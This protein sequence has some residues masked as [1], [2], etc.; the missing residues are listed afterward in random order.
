[1]DAPG[2]EWCVQCSTRLPED[3]QAQH[4][5]RLFSYL[6]QWDRSLCAS[7]EADAAVDALVQQW[8][9]HLRDDPAFLLRAARLG[10][11][12]ALVGL[13]GS[14]R[15]LVASRAIGLLTAVL[16]ADGPLTP[17][18][19]QVEALLKGPPEGAGLWSSLLNTVS[20]GRLCVRRCALLA[21][22]AVAS[23]HAAALRASVSASSVATMLR[24]VA[25]TRGCFT[26][27][28]VQAEGKIEEWVWYDE[29]TSKDKLHSLSAKDL[30]AMFADRASESS[31]TCA[32]SLL[33][34]VC[35]K[36]L[37][38]AVSAIKAAK[39]ALQ[40]FV[41][42][43]GSEHFSADD[44]YL[45][46]LGLAAVLS[47][48]GPDTAPFVDANHPCAA[49]MKE[50]VDLFPNIVSVLVAAI[51]KLTAP[52]MAD[53]AKQTGGKKHR[54]ASRKEDEQ[55]VHKTY[56]VAVLLSHCLA[57]LAS[58]HSLCPIL[59]PAIPV[60]AKLVAR[61]DVLTKSRSK[62]ASFHSLCGLGDFL[63]FSDPVEVLA[64]PLLEES[65]LVLGRLRA[66]D[67]E[68]GVSAAVPGV[69]VRALAK[70]RAAFV[71]SELA[72]AKTKVSFMHVAQQLEQLW[73]AG[74]GV[75]AAAARD[76]KLCAAS[77][78]RAGVQQCS[79]CK[80]VAYCSRECQKAHWPV[81]KKV[82][83]A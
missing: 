9:Q 13:A 70:S 17:Q 66:R 37:Q 34:A 73:F 80:K 75:A 61:G 39:D 2:C 60:L 44:A 74:E 78:G 21:V 65:L 58:V 12:P 82:C 77:C 33:W 32:C 81:H 31:L 83:R 49:V 26:Q 42:V 50:V 7:P 16:Y 53:E 25:A 18:P 48:R 4:L 72:D 46:A 30:V 76:E 71:V 69:D 45:S 19:G 27:A 14:E 15:P 10:A 5:Q 1:M 79:R 23:R 38:N 29:L 28:A 62:T 20:H 40:M 55:G 52:L 3:Q 63:G 57:G 43:L 54:Q 41:G 8:E 35:D 36:D 6:P 56:L 22:Q 51:E 11:V 64:G 59:S 47:R 67:A 24:A 68:G